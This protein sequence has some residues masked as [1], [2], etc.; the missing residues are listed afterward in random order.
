MVS[1]FLLASYI[2]IKPQLKQENRL[3]F[4]F[5]WLCN[6]CSLLSSLMDTLVRKMTYIRLCAPCPGGKYTRIKFKGFISSV[7]IHK[8]LGRSLVIHMI[9]IYLGLLIIKHF[10]L[11]LWEDKSGIKVISTTTSRQAKDLG[12][13]LIIQIWNKK[14]SVYNSHGFLMRFFLC[15][16]VTYWFIYCS[17]FCFSLEFNL[18]KNSAFKIQ[19]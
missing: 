19:H 8:K 14:N 13:K 4:L 16:S 15:F 2:Y 10:R 6:K 3:I 1:G 12:L 7:L 9:L 17:Y 18:Q 11:Y 5:C